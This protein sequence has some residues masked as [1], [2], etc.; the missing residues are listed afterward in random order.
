MKLEVEKN[1]IFSLNFL[2]RGKNK[3]ENIDNFTLYR[4]V[5]SQSRNFSGAVSLSLLIISVGHAWAE[6]L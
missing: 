5:L 1:L 3:G 4:V 2:T 6:P